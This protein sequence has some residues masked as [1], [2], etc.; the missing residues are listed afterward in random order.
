MMEPDN[1]SVSYFI[2]L[3]GRVYERDSATTLVILLHMRVEIRG[4]GND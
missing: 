4:Y 1:Q 3:C 2:V